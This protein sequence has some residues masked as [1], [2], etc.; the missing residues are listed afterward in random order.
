M[1]ST[2]ASEN[3]K[4]GRSSS[5]GTAPGIERAILPHSL[6][7]SYITPLSTPAWSARSV[8]VCPVVDG[9]DAN[10]PAVWIDLEDD[11]VGPD[12]RG[13]KSDQIAPQWFAYSVWVLESGTDEVVQDCDSDLVRESVDGSAGRPGDD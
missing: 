8:D 13:V 2:Y 5:T 9:D 12:P 4:K 6:R 11:P 10:C 1:P 3:V 7:H